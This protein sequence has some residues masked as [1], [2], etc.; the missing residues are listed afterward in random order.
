M[1]AAAGVEATRPSSNPYLRNSI[2]VIVGIIATTLP[3]VNVLMRIPL[4]NLLKNDLHVDRT[5]ASTFIFITGLAWYAK[6]LIGI[7]NDSFPLFGTRRQSYMVIGASISTLGLIATVLMPHSYNLLL[8]ILVLVNVGMVI[9]SCAM[10][11][12]LVETAQEWG[13]S[14]RLAA[15]RQGVDA[16]CFV[17]SGLVSGYLATLVFGLTA[18]ICA[19]LAFTIIP[20]AIVV[21]REPYR[22]PQPLGAV[23][24]QLKSIVRARPMWGA[25]GLMLLFYVAPG[26]STVLFYRQQNLLHMPT[27][28]Q[29]L[30]VST[31]Y[32]MSIATAFVYSF[33]C[34]RFDLRH[35]LLLGIGAAAATAILY[36]FYSSV[37]AAF[38]IDGLNGAGYTLAELAFLDL[39]A[40]AAPVGSESLGYSLM[41]SVRNLALFGTDIIGS[42]LMD[43]FGWSFSSLV[44][45]NSAT[46]ALALPFVFLLPVALVCRKDV[47]KLATHAESIDEVV[48]RGPEATHI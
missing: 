13:A 47:A 14:G 32:A 41:L 12:L 39:C 25:A 19:F 7:I 44:L 40:R 16:V 8:A 38:L 27:E 2:V 21:L 4:L 6:P 30:L 11:G 20:V 31:Q 5:L 33:L 35:L 34:R 9:S 24:V 17:L 37:P 26:M 1:T 36:L 18:G 43:S 45:I 28:M 3:Q 15:T 48:P 22:A 23:K 46:T 10:G 29:G 42:K